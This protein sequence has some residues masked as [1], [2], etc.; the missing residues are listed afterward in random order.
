MR[1]IYWN[2][3][4]SAGACDLCLEVRLRP[5]PFRQYGDSRQTLLSSGVEGLLTV[6]CK[7]SIFI[8][9]SICHRHTRHTELNTCYQRRIHPACKSLRHDRIKYWT[10]MVCRV[11]DRN[12]INYLCNIIRSY[13]VLSI[14]SIFKS[15][16]STNSM[17]REYPAGEFSEFTLSLH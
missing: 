1:N 7:S 9:Y 8:T 5:P 11:R 14:R 16:K 12:W 6:M 2:S 17:L 3:P 4:R 10:C 15:Y 13:Q